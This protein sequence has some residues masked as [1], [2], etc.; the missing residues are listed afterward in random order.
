M[1]SRAYVLLI[2]NDKIQMY[3]GISNPNKIQIHKMII[4]IHGSSLL[5][6]PNRHE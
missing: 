5:T 4:L 3:K 1:R 6:D 2:Y